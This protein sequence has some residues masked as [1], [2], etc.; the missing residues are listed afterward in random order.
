[1]IQ[2]RA[3]DLR[4]FA[5]PAEDEV[6]Q[7]IKQSPGN[8]AGEEPGQLAWGV[9]KTIDRLQ[10]QIEQLEAAQRDHRASDDEATSRQL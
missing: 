6:G 10:S 2:R 3:T 7:K 4:E 1:M 8:M 5:G 9:D